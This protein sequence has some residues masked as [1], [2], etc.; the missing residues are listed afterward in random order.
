MYY[1]NGVNQSTA[2][3]IKTLLTS[4]SIEKDNFINIV[5]MIPISDDLVKLV[6]ME[7][8]RTVVVAHL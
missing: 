6:G 2:P 7:K 3:T 4:P 5:E 1:K 8:K